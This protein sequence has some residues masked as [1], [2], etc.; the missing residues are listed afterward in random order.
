ME[1]VLIISSRSKQ[2]MG[3]AQAVLDVRHIA[4]QGWLE[5]RWE[6]YVTRRVK[7]SETGLGW[8]FPWAYGVGSFLAR[9]RT[10]KGLLQLWEWE[11]KEDLFL[12][13]VFYY[14]IPYFNERNTAVLQCVDKHRRN[15]QVLSSNAVKVRIVLV[16]TQKTP[17]TPQLVD[18]EPNWEY[19]NTSEVLECGSVDLL[20]IL[21]KRTFCVS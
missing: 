10:T 7:L 20:L 9:S 19:R 3:C 21:F 2:S 17:V 11:P 14:S 6:L 4:D 1:S 13:V 15:G 8:G 16:V 12:W 18:T 5:S